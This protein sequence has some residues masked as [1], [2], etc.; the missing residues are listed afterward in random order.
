MNNTEQIEQWRETDYPASV[1]LP[2]EYFEMLDMLEQQQAQ[3]DELTDD[4]KYW[5][6]R[7]YRH[8]GLVGMCQLE[9]DLEQLKNGGEL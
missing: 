9:E 3:I 8:A 5:K 6:L 1:I 7:A 2:D 4:V